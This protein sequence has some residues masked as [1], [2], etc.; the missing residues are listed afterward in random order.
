LSAPNRPAGIPS[1]NQGIDRIGIAFG[2]AAYLF[3]GF[4]PVY[5]KLLDFSAPIEI[6]AHRVVWSVLVL[7]VLIA[8]RRQLTTLRKLS[9]QQTGW[10]AVSGTLVAVNWMVFIW[11]LLNDRML[12]TSLGY[13]INPL[14]TVLLGGLFLGEWLRPVQKLAVVLAAFGVVNEIVAVGVLPWAG[15]TL[16]ISFGLYGLVRKRLAVDSA[17]GLGVETLLMLPLAIGYL[18][19]GWWVGE[20]A[21]VRGDTRQV[22]LLAVG[23]LVTVFPLVCFAAAALRLP[24][25][26]LGF[27]QYLAPSITFLLAIY[28]YDEPI[29]TSQILTFGCIWVALLMFS[30]ESLYYQRRLAARMARDTTP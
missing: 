11:A 23:G 3:W 29:R 4:A 21:L 8:V 12:E 26:I 22:L 14:V 2:L 25:S 1:G 15:L 9:L 24:L 13:Y 30:T 10:L 7:A 18:V 20:G 27:L 28:V 19:W 17:V 6:V 5:F 16:A